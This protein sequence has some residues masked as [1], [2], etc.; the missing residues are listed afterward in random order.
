MRV[1]PAAS[2]WRTAI[3]ADHRSRIAI[4][5]GNSW[6]CTCTFAVGRP[7]PCSFCTLAPC[8]TSPALAPFTSIS[9]FGPSFRSSTFVRTHAVRLTPCGPVA[10]LARFRT[11]PVVQPYRRPSP[12]LSP[13]ARLL[14]PTVWPHI[15][16]LLPT[17]PAFCMALLAYP[18]LSP[19]CCA[20]L[21]PAH[22]ASHYTLPCT[23]R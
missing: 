22:P 1:P 7:R 13:L 18:P 5:P 19:H 21:P 8:H 4:A 3:R 16:L 10:D 12:I 14:L 9:P 6:H 15:F 17:L 11:K 23:L 20:C 2:L